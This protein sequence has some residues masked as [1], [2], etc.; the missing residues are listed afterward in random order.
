M[1][2]L[3]SVAIPCV[4][5]PMAPQEA[6]QATAERLTRHLR[7]TRT[8]AVLHASDRPEG[9]ALLFTGPLTDKYAE[10]VIVDRSTGQRLPSVGKVSTKVGRTQ[11][12]CTSTIRGVEFRF[13]NLGGV[14][15]L[16]QGG[17]KR[18]GDPV[19]EVRGGGLLYNIHVTEGTGHVELA[20]ATTG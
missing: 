17:S 10:Y 14:E 4:H 6:A 16:D 11:V 12:T 5:S 20:T 15:I 9:Y 19:L 8:L 1:A 18:S 13:S 2:V 3:A 7:L